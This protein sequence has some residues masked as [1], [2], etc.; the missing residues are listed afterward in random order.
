MP[1]EPTGYLFENRTNTEAI[2]LNRLFQSKIRRRYS[3]KYTLYSAQRD[4]KLA[5][6]TLPRGAILIRTVEPPSTTD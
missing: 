3:P 1:S 4:V 6:K 5:G 2:A